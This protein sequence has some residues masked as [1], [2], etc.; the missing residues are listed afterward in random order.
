MLNE[1]VIE[2]LLKLLDEVWESIAMFFQQ[3]CSHM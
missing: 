3:L 1:N 2:D